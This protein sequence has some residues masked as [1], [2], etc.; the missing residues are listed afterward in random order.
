MFSNI[1]WRVILA[2]VVLLAG[3]FLIYW[4][5]ASNSPCLSDPACLRRSIIILVLT[6]AVASYLLNRYLNRKDAI[7]IKQLTQVTHR[8]AQGETDARILPHE[9]GAVNDLIRGFNIMTDR[10]RTHLNILQEENK[11]F[12]TLLSNMSDGVIIVDESGY[13]RLL[14]RA[15]SKLLDAKKSSATG[16][17]FAEVVRHHQLIDIWNKTRSTATEQREAVEIGKEL[18]LQVTITPYQEDTAV[19]FLVILQDLTQ[20]HHL[21]TVRRDFISNI[22]H[23]LRTP[24]A[25]LKAVVET[26]QDG[27]L[28][29]PP[30]A[31]RFLRRAASEID[32][33]TQ[34]V[35][36]LLELSKIESGQVPLRVQE[37]TVADLLLDPLERL[38]PFAARKNINLSVDVSAN[39]PKVLAD[40]DRMH[41]VVSNLLHNAI[42]FT[43]EEGYINIFA[44]MDTT[45]HNEINI[46]FED[47]GGGIP[48]ED[49][50]RIFERFYKSDRARTRHNSGT[51]LG[52]AISR[53]IVQAH[54]GRIGVDSREGRGSIFYFTLPVVEDTAQRP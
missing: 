20:I 34:M 14:N 10:M 29:D 21:Q 43:P 42:K 41:R 51:G 12:R 45:V 40:E 54:N 17:S 46:A 9:Q 39:L 24:L 2:Y 36:E 27:A 3:I 53:H 32:T 48:E 7:L 35:E 5:Y 25:S 4:A 38:K 50:P 44:K 26:L 28:D 13:V 16:R 1:R 19:G 37:T 22:S 31:H 33:L 8:I 47:N 6:T 52:L 49:L 18:F 15:A 30:V 23:E 11:Q